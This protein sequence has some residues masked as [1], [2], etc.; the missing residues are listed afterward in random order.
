MKPNLEIYLNSSEH[1][2]DLSFSDIL[3]LSN[4]ARLNHFKLCSMIGGSESIRDLQESKNL[5]SEAYEFP[6]IESI[7]A[8]SKIFNALEK[9]YSGNLYALSNINIF[10]NISSIMGL[11][12]F[13]ELNKLDIPAIFNRRNII[14][15]FDRRLLAI[16][17]GYVK[18]NH[19][20]L[21]DIEDLVNSLIEDF[22]L[23]I[24]K[25]NFNS[26][27]SGGITKESIVK[28]WGSD[29]K[30]TFI[31]T[32]LFT[33]KLKNSRSE[34]LKCIYELQELEKKLLMLMNKTIM[35]KNEYLKIREK[36][37]EGYLQK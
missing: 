2:Y 35:Q 7:F 37:L 23:Q 29:L 11:N 8:I 17:K 28:I 27:I 24:K 10:I 25:E 4:Y 31:K 30:P 1:I 32:G 19:F 34:L 26:S 21:S 15:N 12:L 18:N 16:S 6:M 20:E 36:H 5:F 22:L 33:V 3:M 14:F 9:I 13:K